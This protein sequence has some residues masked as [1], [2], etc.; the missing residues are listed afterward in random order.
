VFSC[1]EPDEASRK[2]SIARLP[3]FTRSMRPPT[4]EEARL[5]QLQRC[6]RVL[7]QDNDT[8]GFFVAVLHLL[9]DHSPTPPEYQACAVEEASLTGEGKKKKHGGQEV[10]AEAS[11]EIMRN[12]GYNPKHT[13][14]NG[15]ARASGNTG[16]VSK[17][18]P[19]V[20]ATGSARPDA[21]A[22][23]AP[24]PPKGEAAEGPVEYRLLGSAESRLVCEGLQLDP[25]WVAAADSSTPSPRY[26][27]VSTVAVPTTALGE[28]AEEGEDVQ[29][30]SYAGIFGS[31]ATGWVRQ[32]PV[33]A[34]AGSGKSCGPTTRYCLVS[35][36]VRAALSTWASGTPMFL[37]QAG[38]AVA[39]LVDGDTATESEANS[40]YRVLADA[41][42]VLATC[43]RKELVVNLGPADFKFVL[44]LA[45]QYAR[46]DVQDADISALLEQA[47]AL[48][49]AD[50]DPDGASL[51]ELSEEAAELQV[52]LAGGLSAEGL[53]RLGDAYR[54]QVAV[55]APDSVMHV[56]VVCE[57]AVAMAAEGQAGSGEAATGAAAGGEKRRLSKA[58][59]KKLKAAPHATS[60]SATSTAAA[61]GKTKGAQ[62]VQDI[63]R[64]SGGAVGGRGPE[65]LL[66]EVGDGAVSLRTATDVCRSYLDAL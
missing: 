62:E 52:A 30:D 61:A 47:A 56:Y 58:E 50:F 59:R 17:K 15:T 63:D 10:S 24:N 29:E 23:P 36:N 41:A 43:A 21:P 9:P 64:S 60:S 40:H 42:T 55:V 28:S 1:G 27:L 14:I 12:L 5:M 8:G 51:E 7:P 25:A 3:A 57:A 46:S 38:V 49:A 48:T 44:K 54:E 66:L 32:A 22:A 19:V 65:V 31:K 35:E 34:S 16:A 26:H 33:A 39:D 2:A 53:Q 11:M 45:P 13:T 20:T 37:R 18:T 6:H 4:A